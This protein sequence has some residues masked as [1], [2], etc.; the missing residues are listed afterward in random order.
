[1]PR[2][3]WVGK[4]LLRT[5]K[6]SDFTNSPRACWGEPRGGLQL[7]SRRARA[8]V[9]LTGTR[10]ACAPFTPSPELA[11]YLKYGFRFM[12]ESAP[13]SVR[14]TYLPRRNGFSSGP[15][16]PKAALS[17]F[18]GVDFAAPDFEYFGRTAFGA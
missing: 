16:K 13:L 17:I 6:R 7:A 11:Q 3:P 5:E 9:I 4:A 18:D 1:M 10:P 14:F 2:P 8:P 12:K 15:W